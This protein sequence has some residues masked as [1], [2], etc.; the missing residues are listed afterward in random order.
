[1]RPAVSVKGLGMTYRAPVREAG[2]WPALRSVV[3]R[4]YRHIDAVSELTFDLHAGEVVGFVG[5]NGA[6]KT[7]TMKILSGILHPT[8]GEARVLGHVPWRRRHEYL[9]QIALVRGSQPI[10][11]PA[12][13]TVL[14]SLRYQ[15]I[16]YEIPKPDF[17]ANLAELVGLLDLDSLLDRQVRALSLGERMRAG[18]AITLVY[19][20][21]VLFLDEPTIGLDVTAAAALR[22]FI[23]GYAVQSGATV[24]LTS[25][26]VTDVESLCR[27]VILIEHSRVRYDGDF[28]S[29]DYFDREGNQ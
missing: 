10:G 4:R 9:K 23:A 19:R 1:M 29:L 3:H 24:L 5:P 18:L 25:H 21:K 11:G 15:Q 7:T 12:E 13:L 16:L 26:Y 8:V 17:R 27:R 28:A 22:R 20:P 14:D 2:L 6:G